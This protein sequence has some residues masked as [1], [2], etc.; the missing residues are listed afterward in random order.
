MLPMYV[1]HISRRALFSLLAFHFTCIGMMDLNTAKNVHSYNFNL[2]ELLF[3][4]FRAS[5]EKIKNMLFFSSKQFLRLFG[6][7][8]WQTKAQTIESEYF[9]LIFFF[10]RFKSVIFFSVESSC[11]LALLRLVRKCT[12]KR[13]RV[14]AL[15]FV[16]LYARKSQRISL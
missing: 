2:V 1:T 6:I 13:E 5:N 4:L 15:F 12:T 10:I 9:S 7:F 8:A 16:A 11:V 3:C 14:A